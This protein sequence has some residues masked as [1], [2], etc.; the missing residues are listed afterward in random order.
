MERLPGEH[1]VHRPVR[2]WNRLCRTGKRGYTGKQ[3]NQMSAHGDI[4][5]DR[6]HLDA[7]GQQALGEF[8]GAGAQIEDD[9]RLFLAERL[10]GPA[11]ARF[12]IVR[13]MLGVGGR[14]RTE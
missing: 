13:S 9:R 11:N 5:F 14:L 10:Q 1:R 4:G 3:S 6:D 8:A 2:Q 7:E 12:R